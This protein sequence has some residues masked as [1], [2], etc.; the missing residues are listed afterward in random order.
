MERF[1]GGISIQQ[2]LTEHDNWARFVE[3]N[4]GRIRPAVYDN[5]R[6]LMQCRTPALGFHV[7]ECP[8][9]GE[10]RVVPHTC[11]SRLCASCG[12]PA[13]D[14]W[15]NQV[16]NHTLNVEYHHVVLSVPW[17]LR[18]LTLLNRAKMLNIFLR[19]AAD[20]IMNWCKTYKDFTPGLIAVL[21][22]FGADLKFHPHVHLIVTAG[23]LSLDGQRWVKL[24]HGFLMPQAGLKKRWRYEVTSRV[25]AAHRAGELTMPEWRPGPKG[26]LTMGMIM[27]QVLKLI[28]Y[29]MIGTSLKQI[30]F[31]V[32]Y[33]G[34]YTRRP[35]IGESRI[36]RFDDKWVIFRY[37]DYAQGGQQAIKK[38]RVMDF[39]A[40]L[41]RHIPDK[42]FRMVRHYGIFA[43]RVR[44]AQL[45]RA[46]A[47]LAQPEPEPVCAPT[48]RE[49]WL[50]RTGVDPLRCRECGTEMVLVGYC[51]GPHAALA[52]LIGLKP[53]ERIEYRD[54]G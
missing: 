11:K 52:A 14:H 3:A 41:V 12:K 23:G 15:A 7:Y 35:V 24:G 31:A 5:V 49:R 50:E 42:H 25:N 20:A 46:R 4:R 47:L 21:H 26:R 39:I 28:W 16:L 48:W 17:H 18:S 6:R 10:Q 51:F 27:G 54:T 30:G 8:D 1:S 36:I 33:I 37:K 13:T 43:T 45:A 19:G 2:I 22:T 44:G 53:G 40:R 34:R 29:V 9:C 38:L 32:S